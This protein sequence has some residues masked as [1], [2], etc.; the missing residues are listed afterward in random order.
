MG[1]G[2]R[3]CGEGPVMTLV[4]RSFTCV[5][6]HESCVACH[7]SCVACHDSCVACPESCVA[8]HKIFKALKRF[9]IVGHDLQGGGWGGW[10]NQQFWS[11]F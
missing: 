6:S 10:A 8:C 7:E 2:Q 5:A 3:L 11:T 9:C 4:H 1:K